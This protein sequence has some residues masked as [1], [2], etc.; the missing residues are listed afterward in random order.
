VRNDSPQRLNRIL[1]IVL[2]LLVMFAAVA[3]VSLAWSAPGG[4]IDRMAA[5]AGWLRDHDNRDTKTV[6]TLAASVV[7]LLMGLTIILELTPS[8]TQRMRVRNIRMG[9]AVISTTE[10]AAR[11]DAEV[12]QIE[13]VAAC[14][15]IVAAHGRRVEV[16]LDLDVDAGA[17]LSRAADEACGRTQRTIEQQIDIELTAR[18]RARLHYRELRLLGEGQPHR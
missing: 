12:A 8:G 13:H 14:R 18:P 3:V 6:I 10:I 1:I 11:I 17:V 5:F 2:A 7:A 15:S 16:V 9:D 4:T